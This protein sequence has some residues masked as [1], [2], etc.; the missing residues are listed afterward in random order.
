M[1]NVM[2]VWVNVLRLKFFPWLKKSRRDSVMGNDCLVVFTIDTGDGDCHSFD[3][4]MNKPDAASLVDLFEAIRANKGI[5]GIADWESDNHLSH[6]RGYKLFK[7][8]VT[9][10]NDVDLSGA[11]ALV[12]AYV[13][14]SF[15]QII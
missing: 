4:V 15:N 3:R 10:N 12:S 7:A 1:M 11:R 2:T 14:T 5:I 9:N 13:S 8:I 6:N